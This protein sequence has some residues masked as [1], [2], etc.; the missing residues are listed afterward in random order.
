M[1]FQIDFENIFNNSPDGLT[2]V[3]DGIIVDTNP[4]SIKLIR[5]NSK[6]E[7]IGRNITEFIHPDSLELA[8]SQIETLLQ[9]GGN[10]SRVIIKIKC[11]DGIVRRFEFSALLVEYSNRKSILIISKEIEN[12]LNEIEELKE[13]GEKLNAI[14][15]TIP[16]LMFIINKDKIITKYFL[17]DDSLLY[18]KKELFLGKN[19]YE[20]LPDYLAKLTDEKV[21]EVLHTGITQQFEYELEIRNEIKYFSSILTKKSDEET[22]ATIRDITQIKKTELA[23]LE[24]LKFNSI[25]TDLSIKFINCKPEEADSII[26]QT[27]SQVGNYFKVDR[28]FV[29]E[30]DFINRTMSCIYEWCDIGITSE[31]ENTQNMDMNLYPDFMKKMLNKET[32]VIEDIKNFDDEVIRNTLEA[33][34]VLSTIIHPIFFENECFGNVGFDYVKSF[35][36]FSEREINF[37]VLF[38]NFLGV[39]FQRIK[40]ERQLELKNKE[41]EI[42]RLATLNIIEDLQNEINHRKKTEIELKLNEQKFRNY[43]EQTQGA[44]F[45]IKKDGKYSFISQ[46]IKNI[47]GIDYTEFLGKYFSYRIYK[48]DVKILVNQLKMII[49]TRKSFKSIP[50]RIQHNDGHYV[51]IVV[52]A[53][54]I[55]DDKNRITEIIGVAVDVDDLIRTKEL[56]QASELKY[57]SLFENQ[58]EAYA[59]HEIIL[60]NNNSPVDFR[61]LDVNKAF[62]ELFDIESKEKLIGKCVLDIWPGFDKELIEI[63]GRITLNGSKET[64]EKFNKTFNKTFLINVYSI[65]TSR[66]AVSYIDISHK[67]RSEIINRIQFNIADAIINFTSLNRLVLTIR[68]ELSNI[69]DTKNF[70]V[71]TYDEKNDEFQTVVFIDEK[72]PSVEKW[73]AKGSLSG[74]TISKKS[75]VLLKKEEIFE[76]EKQFGHKIPGSDPEIWLGVPIMIKNKIIGVLVVQNYENPDAYDQTTIQ[77]LQIISNQIAIF[78]EQQEFEKQNRLLS[79]AVQES[80]AL[81]IITER[82]GNILYANKKFLE[83]TKYSLDEVLGKNPRILKSNYHDAAFYAEIWRN[84]TIGK[85]WNGEF[86]NKDKYGQFYWARAS[87]NPI[88]DDNGIVSHFVAI[89][90]D[91]TET[92]KLIEKILSSE[93][94][95][96]TIWDNSV[97]GMRLTNEFGIIVDVNK[98]LCEM[99]GLEKENFIG[100]PYYHFVKN[101]QGKGLKSFSEKIITGN[102]SERK[103]YL[104]ELENGKTISVETSNTIIQL[105][106]SKKYLFTIFRDVTEKKKIINDLIAAKEKAEEMNRIKSQF[107]AI[108]SHELRT[109]F[110]GILGYTELLREKVTDEEGILFLDGIYRSS[111]RMI[112]TLTNILDISKFEADKIETKKEPTEIKYL[113]LEAFE[114][115]RYQAN[116]K[117]L[118][119]N[120]NINLPDKFTIL[121]NDKLFRSIINNLLSNAIKFTLKGGI[122]LNSYI[123]DSN[124][125]IEVE[126]TGIGIPQDKIDLIFDEFRQ[127]SE[128]HARAFEGTGLGLAI[129][130]KFTETLGV[131]VEVESKIN[132]GS[133]FKLTFPI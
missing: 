122:N 116:K 13:N 12:Y 6:D 123:K 113:L 29:F 117:N 54:P 3:Q 65:D 33:Q 55:L 101:Y 108:M 17:N 8:L 60:D 50:I 130:K 131:K 86:L 64:F 16:D 37:L 28:V 56:L 58:L 52:N 85:T 26:N 23:L 31:M 30:Y 98:A 78:I 19:I 59:L 44:I 93:K 42:A 104:L 24:E 126:D 87:I 45:V 94:Q 107:F 83:V 74:Y 14:I 35:K 32:F 92:K 38:A 27:L 124:L 36:K 73:P 129:V 99:Y 69:I 39:V 40:N 67:K 88:V 63:F 48:D 11:F 103:E 133:K 100:K 125:I 62:L 46:A 57:Q 22:L 75:P 90:E 25:I 110:M 9:T 119:F 102:I 49:L 132:V 47:V 80:S 118:F 20:I 2:I 112:E 89:Q 120:K 77:L 7:I 111:N 96:R 109:P 106:D 21:N 114:N 127:V 71:A 72:D 115:F 51:W 61:F 105:E 18:Q 79:K 68:D 84:I 91:I 10:L 121:S 53:G 1:K 76:I 15:R 34:G 41:L 43:V 66:F 81:V 128:G 95:L 82:D 70:F 5:A 4:S 97:D